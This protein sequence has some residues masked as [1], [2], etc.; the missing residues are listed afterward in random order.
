M[1]PQPASFQIAWA[2]TRNRN[3]SGL[4][5]M[6]TAC[7]PLARRIWLISPAPPKICWKTE[8]TSTQEK[9]CGR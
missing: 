3:V 9:K 4:V 2:V 1:M 6:S 8:T 7:Q 5:M